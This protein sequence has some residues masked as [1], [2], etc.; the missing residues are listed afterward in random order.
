R[1]LRPPSE[2]RKVPRPRLF[3]QNSPLLLTA[4]RTAPRPQLPYLSQPAFRRPQPLSGPS[5]QIAR[6][7]STENKR[8]VKEQVWLATKW[9][10]IAWTFLILGGITWYGLNIE[11]DERSNPTPA[12]WSFRTRQC[13]RAARAYSD[14]R[15]AE[16]VGFVD[17][18]K[19][20]SELRRALERLEDA[21][22]DGK[23]L[24]ELKEG[25]EEVLIP[26]AG[27]AGFDISSKSW[28]WRAGYFE[29]IMGCATAAEHMDGMVLDKTRGIVFPREV[30]VGPSNPDPRPAPPYMKAAPKEEDCVPPFAPPE[31]FYIRILTGTGFTT[32][33]KMS[34]ARA[35]ANWLG[36]K[37]LHESA[38][39]MYCWA[40]DIAKGALSPIVDAED[41]MDSRSAVLKDGP[42]AREI[43]P[44]LLRATTDLAIHHA[45]TGN[46]SSALPILLSVLRARRTAPVSPFPQPSSSDPSAQ[47]KSDI[48]TM[49]TNIFTPPKFPPPPPSGDN[50]L[51]RASEKPTCEESEL[52]L[53]IGEILF[54]SSSASS[55][56][57]GW[58]KQAVNIADANMAHPTPAVGLDP[59]EEKRKCKE[60]LLT[61]V[62]NWD[63]M[64]KRIEQKGG[65]Q[66]V[67]TAKGWFG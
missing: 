56:G 33:Q 14:T 43:T 12:E 34:A 63:A 41:I 23:D 40:V 52:M 32:G 9:T 66:V 42:A 22:V 53:Y 18:A 4:H 6:L 21:S 51:I 57:L 29:V 65:E 67:E 13:L 28:P 61:G 62:G 8:F 10:A 48:G 11:M 47:P 46:V 38:E 27:R 1:P 20:G 17:W 31:T 37:K 3:T 30:V 15:R 60:C 35:Y 55:E 5:Q 2:S 19:V 45:R 44:N 25:G 36:Y 16:Q 50:P 54:A 64:L 26:G 58:T 7:L 49:I 39:E 24:H 59:A